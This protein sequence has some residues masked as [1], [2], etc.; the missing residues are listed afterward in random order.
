M[1]GRFTLTA[2]GDELAEAF[3]LEPEATA[4]VV[5]RYNIAPSQDVLVVRQAAGHRTLTS[6]RWGLAPPWAA[7]GR[8]LINARFESAAG[9]PAFRD[10]LRLRR[11]LVPASG[12]FE[13]KHEASHRQPFLFRRHDRQPLAFAGLIDTWQAPDSAP[14]ESCAILTCAPNDLVAPVHDRMPLILG[15]DDHALWLDPAVTS[16]A[17]L[18]SLG[19]AYPAELMEAV[20]VSTLVNRAD[21]DEPGCIE[22]L[23]VPWQSPQLRLW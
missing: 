21:V 1:C 18:A 23:P 3:G 11:C 8:Q 13:W 5:P 10:A 7:P 19:R 2:P 12:F 17:Q 22:A 4:A 14:R 16:P 9:R 20:A 15:R 6:V